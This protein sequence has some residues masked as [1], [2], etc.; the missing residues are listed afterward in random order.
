V[1]DRYRHLIYDADADRQFGVG[2]RVSDPDL[3]FADLPTNE[4]DKGGSNAPR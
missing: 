2:H 4:N 3:P 1:L